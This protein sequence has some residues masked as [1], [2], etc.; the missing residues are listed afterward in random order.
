MVTQPPPWGAY[1][2]MQ[3]SYWTYTFPVLCSKVKQ[4][5]TNQYNKKLSLVTKTASM[6]SMCT[7][8]LHLWAR[9]FYFI[10][11]CSYQEEQ[12]IFSFYC[13][14]RRAKYSWFWSETVVLSQLLI[15]FD[16]VGTVGWSATIHCYYCYYHLIKMHWQHNHVLWK[17]KVDFVFNSCPSFL[18]QID[19]LLYIAF[20]TLRNC[21]FASN[22]NCRMHQ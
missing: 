16:S 6:I 4:F 19:C 9:I 7:V 13:Y 15:W 10:Y 2:K 20:I 17:S 12:H 5:E 3:R 21:L 11:I 8:Q 1:S 22:W 14:F 18:R